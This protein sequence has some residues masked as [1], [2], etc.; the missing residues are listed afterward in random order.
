MEP[1]KENGGEF[2]ERKSK[3]KRVNVTLKTKGRVLERLNSG[4]NMGEICDE[5]GVH[6]STVRKWKN[7]K[8]IIDK[9]SS[10]TLQPNRKRLRDPQNPHL[11]EAVKIWFDNCRKQGIPVSG[12][13]VK[14]KAKS[15]N[16]KLGGDEKFAASNGWLTRWKHQYKVTSF[17]ISGEKLSAD[18]SAAESFKLQFDQ[19]IREENLA[20][21][22][23]F[24]A[25]ETGLNF[26][27]LPKRTLGVRQ[28]G[29]AGHKMNTERLTIMPCTN[30]DGSLKLPLLVIG[31]SAKPRALK[32]LAADNLPVIYTH[33]AKA[34]MNCSIFEN[35]FRKDF[36]PRVKAF[37]LSRG[38]LPKAILL[39]DN[40]GSHPKELHEEGI[41]VIFL[42]P[43]VTSLIQPLDQGIIEN[44]KKNYRFHFVLSLLTAQE[45]GIELL[46]QLKKITIKDVIFWIAKSWD[47][48]SPST[49][50][51]CWKPLIS[52]SCADS[53]Q[54]NEED[55]QAQ[56]CRFLEMYLRLQNP[57]PINE[58]ELRDWMRTVDREDE[59]QQLSD[60]EIISR[61]Q[62]AIDDR[63]FEVDNEM[64]DVETTEETKLI[65]KGM[66][67]TDD[68]GL[69]AEGDN[70][71]IHNGIISPESALNSVDSLLD[72]F[73]AHG[74]LT[75]EETSLLW[76]VRHKAA[77]I[78]YSN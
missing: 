72:F 20:P 24:N 31:K 17:V 28:D 5:I 11:N 27:M 49:I 7:D 58:E 12:E 33:Q 40:A 73:D 51:K 57:T 32:N 2:G 19:L 35:W 71:L 45:E 8:Q 39:L 38:L 41:R 25:D 66:G 68:H 78:K 61:V 70:G 34:W 44:M 43:N 54:T 4:E 13:F 29:T 42:P 74:S 69:K 15:L 56:M 16:I 21:C 77:L 23:I 3:K 65:D 63:E 75:P 55:Q 37:L 53:L 52:S 60:E 18:F 59:S 46:Q 50:H 62:P 6:I 1:D 76:N 26:K 47:E 14:G 30:Y 48:V 64:L 22:Q 36:V 9:I 10:S 67:E